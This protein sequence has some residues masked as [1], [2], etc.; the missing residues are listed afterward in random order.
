MHVLT[1]IFVVLVALLTVVIVPLVAVNATNEASFKQKFKNAEQ[2]RAAAETSLAAERT[3]WLASQQKLEADL[4]AVQAVIGDLRGQVATRA[5]AASKAETELAGTKAAQASV[6][7]SL[8]LL[9]QNGK[10]SGDLTDALVAELRGLRTKTME[11][12]TRL[13]QLQEAF[14]SSQSSLEVA[15]AA[16][17]AL[18]E[19]VKRLGD[20]KD[21]A[22]ATIAEYVARVGELAQAKAGAVS[23]SARVVATKN[24]TATIINVRR[25][26]EAPLA[27][28]NAGSRDGVKAG[29]VLTI[30]D[31]SNFVGNLRITE[32]DVNRAV[33]VIELEDAGSRGE[34]K[35][36][37]RAIARAGE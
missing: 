16:R 33:G 15:D 36:G 30:G 22:I 32:V 6:D 8:Q 13:V 24:L 21:T 3:S 28:I 35:V 5:A 2:L 19:E 14:D 26:D 7:A 27:E 1:K 11:A 31:G 4:A 37:Q 20:E 9:A 29:W 12:E 10:A 18:Q 34:V 23:D 17:R 25:G